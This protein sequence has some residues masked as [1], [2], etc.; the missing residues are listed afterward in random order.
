MWHVLASIDIGSYR[1]DIVNK[2]IEISI[3]RYRFDI[4]SIS[5][6]RRR[7]CDWCLF[8]FYFV[9]NKSRTA[10]IMTLKRSLACYP[11]VCIFTRRSG[12][13]GRLAYLCRPD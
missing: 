5:P 3:Y 11:I 1:I 8:I 10:H 4:V 12:D 2:N 13:C 7:W 9:G 6:K